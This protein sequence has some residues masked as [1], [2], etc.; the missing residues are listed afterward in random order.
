MNFQY[1]DAVGNILY[2]RIQLSTSFQ[3][4][5]WSSFGVKKIIKLRKYSIYKERLS[6]AMWLVQ[7]PC[8]LSHIIYAKCLKNSILIFLKE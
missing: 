8:V 7:A 1:S 5:N 2:G 6:Q 4:I 3:S